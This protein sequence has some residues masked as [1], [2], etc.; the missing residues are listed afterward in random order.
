MNEYICNSSSFDYMNDFD[1][2]YQPKQW[3]PLLGPL[4]MELRLAKNAWIKDYIKFQWAP[5]GAGDDRF[6]AVAR[7]IAVSAALRAWHPA[8]LA[9]T[10]GLPLWFVKLVIV[11]LEDWGWTEEVLPALLCAVDA[12]DVLKFKEIV[13][14]FVIAEF[15]FG[16]RWPGIEAVIGDELEG[17]GT[18]PFGPSDDGGCAALQA[19]W[20]NGLRKE[21]VALETWTN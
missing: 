9:S 11:A 13:D 16:K 3:A 19:A 12:N 14:H 15:D 4:E 2:V 18:D 21:G 20:H 8:D 1:R 10:L 6:S 17:L 5:S 7:I